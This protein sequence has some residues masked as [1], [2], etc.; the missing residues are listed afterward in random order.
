M[1][2]HTDDVIVVVVGST[3]IGRTV[4]MVW[5]LVAAD[6]RRRVAPR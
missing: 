1:A 3:A 5:T 6:T 4:S 2:P